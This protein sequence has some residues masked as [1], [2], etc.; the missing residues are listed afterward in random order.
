MIGM[1]RVAVVTTV[2]ALLMLMG[3][4]ITDTEPGAPAAVR[5]AH[6]STTLTPSGERD[7][8]YLVRGPR[9]CPMGC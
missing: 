9:D 5:A 3:P 7:R 1:A 4:A 2:V 6:S 8:N